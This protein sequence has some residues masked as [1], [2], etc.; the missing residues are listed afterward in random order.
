[1]TDLNKQLEDTSGW[2]YEMQL[3]FQQWYAV[4]GWVDDVNIDL[5]LA[6][7]EE[8]DLNS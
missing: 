2:D 7:K 5:Q 4:E 1:L 3:Q 8:L 6:A